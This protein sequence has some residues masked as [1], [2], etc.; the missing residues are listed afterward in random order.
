M[1]ALRVLV[2]FSREYEFDLEGEEGGTQE[3]WLNWL[4]EQ[5]TPNAFKLMNEDNFIVNIATEEFMKEVG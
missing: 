5:V 2:T 3:Y 1:Q 4:A